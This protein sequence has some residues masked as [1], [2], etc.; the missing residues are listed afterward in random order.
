MGSS[1]YLFPDLN[2]EARRIVSPVNSAGTSCHA[3]KPTYWI[4][5]VD[6]AQKDIIIPDLAPHRVKLGLRCLR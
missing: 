6:L 1:Y 3:L 2:R 4:P 5:T